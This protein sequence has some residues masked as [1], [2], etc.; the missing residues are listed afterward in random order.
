M[1]LRFLRELRA[2]RGETSFFIKRKES[3]IKT[4]MLNK[5][6]QEHG[7]FILRSHFTGGRS[8]STCH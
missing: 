6:G 4:L 7:I 8:L 3:T 2:L 5:D 1:T